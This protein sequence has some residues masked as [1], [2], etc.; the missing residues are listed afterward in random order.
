M[1]YFNCKKKT[2]GYAPRAASISSQSSAKGNVST[3]PLNT[4]HTESKVNIP[5]ISWDPSVYAMIDQMQNDT[6]NGKSVM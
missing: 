2:N 1:I 6:S 4:P 5:H 3:P